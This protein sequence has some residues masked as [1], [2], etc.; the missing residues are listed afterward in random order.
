MC[1][2][3]CMPCSIS[4]WVLFVSAFLLILLCFVLVL[5][6]GNKRREV[7]LYLSSLWKDLHY[8][9]PVNYAHSSGMWSTGSW[10]LTCIINCLVCI[11]QWWKSLCK[12]EMLKCFLYNFIQL[13][14][15]FFKCLYFLG[16]KKNPTHK[17]NPKWVISLPSLPS[18][19]PCTHTQ[20]PQQGCMSCCA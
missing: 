2:T 10:F 5:L 6:I 18:T 20:W 13:F 11:F 16:G 8:T 4:Y 17:P 9:A 14:C 3:F 1:I 12:P 15:L 7:F 19:S